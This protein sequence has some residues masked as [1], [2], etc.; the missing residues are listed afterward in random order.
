MALGLA[1][2]TGEALEH[3]KKL[4]RDGTWDREAFI[5]EMGDQLFYFV[6]IL[7]YFTI[8][9]SEVMAANI[10]KLESRRARGTMRGSGNDR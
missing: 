2:E 8:L 1:G 6:R 5:K 10:E 7:R 3:I 4:I 9:P